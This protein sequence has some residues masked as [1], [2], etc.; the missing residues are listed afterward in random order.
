M[1]TT[2]PITERMI[3][4]NGMQLHTLEAGGLRTTLINAVVSAT[5]R[6]R[7]LGAL[8]AAQKKP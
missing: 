5:E 8:F 2:P 7:E 3:E 1:S 4:T 6:S